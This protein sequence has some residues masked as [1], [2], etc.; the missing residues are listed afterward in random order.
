MLIRITKNAEGIEH[1]LET[2]HKRGRELAR[3][4]LDRRVHLGGNLDAFSSAVQYTQSHKKWSDHYHHITASFALED[5]DVDDE[6]LRKI[7]DDLLDYYYC[8][9][10]KSNLVYACEAHRPLMQSEVNKSTGEINQRLL[11]LHLA[12]S[13]LDVTTDNQLRMIPYCH[14]ADKAFQSSL[15]AK[16]GL[17]DPAD[18]RREVAQTRKEIIERWNC[19]PDATHKQT[20]VAELR[21]ILSSVLDGVESID[22]AKDL[23]KQLDIVAAV[24]MKNQKSGN[25]YLQ[26]QTTLGTKNIN[27]RGNGFESLERLYYNA[28]D[29]ARRQAEGKYRPADDRSNDEIVE[30]HKDWW[31][32]QQSKRKSKQIDYQRVEER[33]EKKFNNTLKEA[34][35]YFVLYQNNIQEELIFGFRIWEKNNTKYLFNNDL[36]VKVYDKPDK[37][38]AQIPDDPDARAKTVRLMLEMAQSKG[39]DLR[40]LNVTGDVEFKT[41][42][43]TQIKALR[44]AQVVNHVVCLPGQPVEPQTRLSSVRQEIFESKERDARQRFSK[45]EIDAIKTELD[46]QSVIDFAVQKY[47]LIGD[48]F[49]VVDG[50][51]ADDRIKAKPRNPIDFLTKVCNVPFSEALPILDKLLHEQRERMPMPMQI[52][53]CYSSNP[54]GL[55]NW[56]SIQ[57]KTFKELEVAVKSRPYSAVGELVDGYRKAENVISLSNVAIFDIDND[58]GMSQLPMVN[59][60]ELLKNTTCMIITSRSHQIEKDGKPAVDRYRVI[61]PLNKPLTPTKDSYRAEMAIIAAK[62]GLAE[63][64]DPKALKDISRQYYK[65][66]EDAITIVNNTKAA[67][68]VD[69]VIHEAAKQLAEQDRI[70]QETRESIK[71][72]VLPSILAEFDTDDYP[73]TIDIDA[74]NALPLDE[75]YEQYTGQKLKVEG[76][77]LMGKGITAGTSSKMSFT[78]IEDNG[79]WLWHDFKSGESG[80]VMTFMRYAAGLN[81]FDSASELEQK[82]KVQLIR[83]NKRYYSKALKNAL[84]K[85][86]ND[87]SLEEHIKTLTKAKF[88]KIDKDTLTIAD[89]EFDLSELGV[90]KF[91]LIQQFKRNREAMSKQSDLSLNM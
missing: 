86:T 57:V 55:G 37:I 45:D 1:Y 72:N 61:L 41:E 90:T 77:Y 81:A 6:T 32:E 29:L 89:K 73:F 4:E 16:Y 42:V 54:N 34:R 60:Q 49:S 24:D 39:W 70:K 69:V 88:V 52:S 30:R 27:L 43:E 20:K 82:F 71:N 35:A 48:H 38:T 68:N 31:L 14:E 67:F 85:A 51:I 65:S 3:D 84:G 15:A 22:E 74:M 91:E 76:S 13:M 18:R 64:A 17:I 78:L 2:G 5:N 21:K 26:V 59:A 9:Y 23:L 46:A 58:P 75:I 83:D 44:A 8:D 7:T 63:F 62:I 56:R 10:D 53:L 40:T 80:N 11:H 28:D 12:V 79:Q 50:K 47:G 87:R 36:G 19:N 25:K 66:P 33:Y